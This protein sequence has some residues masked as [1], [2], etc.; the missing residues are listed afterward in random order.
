MVQHCIEVNSFC[1]RDWIGLHVTACFHKCMISVKYCILVWTNKCHM[2]TALKT[3]SLSISNF[4]I[5]I[6]VACGQ[7]QC[8]KG[9]QEVCGQEALPYCTMTKTSASLSKWEPDNLSSNG[10]EMHHCCQGFVGYRQMMDMF[11][12]F[13][14]GW[15]RIIH[16]PCD[17]NRKAENAENL[18]MMD[19]THLTGLDVVTYGNCHAAFQ[20]LCTC[21]V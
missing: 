14:W 18:F 13:K 10:W 5:K 1:V 15:Y 12:A 20:M 21:G 8:H 16:E 2:K 7:H 19:P 9:L 4:F 3:C 17:I 11:W 6:Q